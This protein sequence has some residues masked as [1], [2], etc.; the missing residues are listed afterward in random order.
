MGLMNG[1]RSKSKTPELGALASPAED[2]VVHISEGPLGLGGA[3]GLSGALNAFP[4]VLSC[5]LLW[6]SSTRG[7]QRNTPPRKVGPLPGG[8][9]RAGAHMAPGTLG[10]GGPQH[11]GAHVV[12]CVTHGLC[13]TTHQAWYLLSASM[14]WGPHRGS[15][16]DF[17]GQMLPPPP[18][19]SWPSHPWPW[20]R[21]CWPVS[22]CTRLSVRPSEP[23]RVPVGSLPHQGT[24][25]LGECSGCQRRVAL[26]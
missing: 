9:L 11:S 14:E 4:R 23:V 21:P 17:V 8:A 25:A 3:D 7:K 20:A 12:C 26:V 24:R 16:Y 2:G 22:G 6:A 13:H 1:V 5:S 19:G 10:S 18:I 15:L